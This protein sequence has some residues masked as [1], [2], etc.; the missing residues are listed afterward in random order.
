MIRTQIYLDENQKQELERLSTERQISVAELIR[1]AVDQ[2]LE[3][4]RIRTMAFDKALDKTF[5]LWKD[6]SDIEAAERFVRTTRQK[7]TQ[8]T[9]R[10]RTTD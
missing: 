7:W 5:G 10:T 2:M 1:T 6:R 8:R 3:E 4:E 9:E